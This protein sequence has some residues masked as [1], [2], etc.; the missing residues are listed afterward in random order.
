MPITELNQKLSNISRVITHPKYRT[1][2]LGQKL[3]KETLPLAGTP[4]IETTATMAQ[5]NPFFE[6]A[7]MTPIHQTTPPKQAR[8][9][10]A[11]LNQFG[12]DTTLLN[13]KKHVT[14]QLKHLTQTQL[15]TLRQTLAKNSHPRLLKE[16]DPQRPYGQQKQYQK[17]IHTANTKKLTKLINITAT[18]LQTKI[19][20]FWQDKE[21]LKDQLSQSS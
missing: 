12:F 11:V 15:T 20:L 2:G 16:L 5:H 10:Q 14:T 13:S 9:I 8:A 3:V 17:E 7:G 19:Y 1:T 21:K 6:R 4:N 18:L